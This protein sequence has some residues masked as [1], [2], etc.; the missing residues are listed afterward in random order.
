MLDLLADGKNENIWEITYKI[1][2][3]K[4]WKL[5]LFSEHR[6]DKNLEI[7]EKMTWKNLEWEGPFWESGDPELVGVESKGHQGKKENKKKMKEKQIGE[8]LK[9]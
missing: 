5:A 9:F 8:G 3:G 7:D 4:T 2:P 6:N 1:Q